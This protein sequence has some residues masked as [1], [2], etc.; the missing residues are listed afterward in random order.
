M[1]REPS[2]ESPWLSWRDSLE[3]K[4][5]ESRVFPGALLKC[6]RSTRLPSPIIVVLII[7]IANNPAVHK[8]AGQSLSTR[9]I[10]PFSYTVVNTCTRLLQNPLWHDATPCSLSSCAQKGQGFKDM[11][12]L[13]LQSNLDLDSSDKLRLLSAMRS[14]SLYG[15]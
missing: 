10:L 8:G 15:V 9:P 4:A 12:S 11:I 2:R 1:G 7:H 6:I 3:K 13:L 14:Q 5:T